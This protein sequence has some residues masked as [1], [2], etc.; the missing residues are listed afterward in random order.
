MPKGALLHAHLDATVNAEVLVQL[1]LQ[2]P[3]IHMRTA[4]RL[5]AAN[6][7]SILPEFRPLAS[8]KDS[9][10]SLT[11][12]S[13]QPGTWVPLLRARED[14]PPDLGGPSGFDRWLVRAMTISPAEAYKTHNTT[15]K[16]YNVSDLPSRLLINCTDMG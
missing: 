3:S 11:A 13:Y 16:V 7:G 4:E 6:M 12:E 1:A 5:T 10:V 15:T 14:F 2:H 8:A 9:P